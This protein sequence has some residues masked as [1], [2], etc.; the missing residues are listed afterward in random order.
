VNKR[1][2]RY[3]TDIQTDRQTNVTKQSISAGEMYLVIYVQLA[4]D[5]F[6]FRLT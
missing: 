6:G 3:V 1:Y 2:I 4:G 5:D